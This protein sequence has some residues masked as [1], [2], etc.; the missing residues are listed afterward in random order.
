[1]ILIP[2][3]FIL[4]AHLRL[5]ASSKRAFSSIKAVTFLPFLAALIKAFTMCDSVATLYNVMYIS[6]TSAST[7]AW[8]KKLNTGIYD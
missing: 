2:A 4:P 1:M 3:S 5:L 7:A 6:L 8:L